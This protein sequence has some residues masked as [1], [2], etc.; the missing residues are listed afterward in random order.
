MKITRK[1]IEIGLID[2]N[3][4]QIAGVPANPRVIID[5]DFKNLREKIRNYPE[6]Y[7]MRP[8]IVYPWNNRF[9]ALCGNMRYLAAKEENWP[10]IPCVILPVETTVEKLRAY[11][12]IDNVQNGQWDWDMLANEWDPIELK[13]FGLKFP[14]PPVVDDDKESK[15]DF[16]DSLVFTIKCKNS[17]ELDDLKTIFKTEKSKANYEDIISIIAY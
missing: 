12:A 6:F 17:N 15:V 1:N 8:T 3:N 11:V 4:G 13:E 10:Q 9:I 5:D 14:E 2:V 7:D 16:S